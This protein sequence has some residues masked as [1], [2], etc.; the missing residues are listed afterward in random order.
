ME[1][2]KET[3]EQVRMNEACERMRELDKSMVGTKGSI[4]A[5]GYRYKDGKRVFSNLD[6]VRVKLEG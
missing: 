2:K 4:V 6:S 5:S 3:T 1:Q